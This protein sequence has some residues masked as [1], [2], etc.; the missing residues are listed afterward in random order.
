M[1]LITRKT[2]EN[3]HGVSEE[4]RLNEKIVIYIECPLENLNKSMYYHFHCYLLHQDSFDFLFRLMFVFFVMK[5]NRA[6]Y[7]MSK[8][9]RA[10][11]YFFLTS[12]TGLRSGYSGFRTT[13]SKFEGLPF[14]TGFMLVS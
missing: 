12:P 5:C 4:I 8:C 7:K 2:E 13:L 14:D 1:N 10:N 9:N 6:M 11:M 3:C